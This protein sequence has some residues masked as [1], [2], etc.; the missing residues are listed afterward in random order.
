MTEMDIYLAQVARKLGGMDREVRDDILQELRSHIT[1]AAAEAGGERAVLTSM[2]PPDAVAARYLGIY[3]YG[4]LYRSLFV[5][6]AFLLAIPTLPL[7]VYA[8]VGTNIAFSATLL[9]LLL[10]VAYLMA[11]AVRAGAYVGLVAGIAGCAARFV[12]LA[13][14]GATAGAIVPDANAWILFTVVSLLL[15]VVGYVPGRARERWRPKDVTM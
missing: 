6:I 1:E 4:R 14:F 5:A 9:F 10:L 13:V 15:I 2:E 11:V 7:L 3:G 12:S 8:G